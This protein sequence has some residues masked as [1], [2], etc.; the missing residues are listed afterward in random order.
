MTAES[1]EGL[2][3]AAPTSASAPAPAPRVAM[4]FTA[5]AWT[6]NV[7]LGRTGREEGEG[8]IL[9]GEVSYRAGA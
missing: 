1:A 7:R 6:F 5:S 3:P 4:L 8:V 2:E 9:M